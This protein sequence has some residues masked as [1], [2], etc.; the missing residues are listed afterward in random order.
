MNANQF[1][2][3]HIVPGEF[4]GVI[5]KLNPYEVKIDQAKQSLAVNH[6]SWD[7]ARDMRY[8][9]FSKL[10]N[11]IASTALSLLYLERYM[12][13]K[14]W[15][16]TW[17]TIPTSDLDW[18]IHIVEYHQF[19]KQGFVHISYSNVEAA[20]R[21]YVRAIDPRACSGGAAEFKSI[22]EHLYR[23]RLAVGTDGIQ[24]LD[25]LRLLRNTIH[26]GGVYVSRAGTSETL[27]YAGRTFEFEHAKVI[28][29]AD[30]DTLAMLMTD[31]VELIIKTVEDSV[32]ADIA[33]IEDPTAGTL[34]PLV[35]S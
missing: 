11:V 24:L 9:V 22:Y 19:T 23:T 14:K 32:I 10:K 27:Q 34:P 26:N 8:T 28:R 6:P 2:T 7:Q 17:R 1:R 20:L 4:E 16:S 12:A 31:V 30:W 21:S 25:V 15:W 35:N 13:D 5:K 33:A 18:T 3:I 29:F